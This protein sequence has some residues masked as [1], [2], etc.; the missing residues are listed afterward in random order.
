MSTSGWSLPARAKT[1]DFGLSPALSQPSSAFTSHIE[2]RERGRVFF[3]KGRP[4]LGPVQ[5]K[6]LS[7]NIG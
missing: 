6:G 4:K 2:K 5:S 1:R 7:L 3:L